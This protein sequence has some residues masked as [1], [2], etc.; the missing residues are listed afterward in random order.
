MKADIDSVTFTREREEERESIPYIVI[1]KG[2]Y[3]FLNIIFLF[4]NFNEDS[5][6]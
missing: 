5:S 4:I 2:N 1:Y 3:I 6:K